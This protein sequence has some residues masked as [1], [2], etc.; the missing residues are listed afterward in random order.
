MSDKNNPPKPGLVQRKIRTKLGNIVT[1]GV[2]PDNPNIVEEPVAARPARRWAAGTPRQEV[3]QEVPAV[4]PHTDYDWRII[5]Y[6]GCC[7]G[8]IVDATLK[9][10]VVLKSPEELTKE[11]ENA[12]FYGKITYE[13]VAKQ[14]AYYQNG[15][16]QL[17]K[18][19]RNLP[20][21][22]YYSNADFNGQISYFQNLMDQYSLETVL[23]TGR[24]YR[25]SESQGPADP[26]KKLLG[27]TL[28]STPFPDSSKTPGGLFV[29][30]DR[31]PGT[32]NSFRDVGKAKPVDLSLLKTVGDVVHQ[33]VS[34][35]IG[36]AVQ[37]PVTTPFIVLAGM[38]KA[39]ATFGSIWG[40]I[41]AYRQFLRP[42]IV[43]TFIAN[44]SQN[45][46]E[47]D[48]KFNEMGFEC[49]LIT[50]NSNHGDSSVLYLYEHVLT[51]EELDQLA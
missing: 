25:P 47:Q 22:R 49:V 14:M 7:G 30:A 28:S 45:D 8:R 43:V 29:R 5:G 26:A 2:R 46:K 31:Q 34:S 37:E 41:K 27:V 6:P 42:G 51:K 48:A 13:S 32:S 44:H 20:S 33:S 50:G 19:G 12:P 35:G 38:S 18:T 40:A 10:P 4:R 21:F 9:A 23:K 36:R 17:T 11:W 15:L 1:R 24:L 39:Y 16:D 3:Q